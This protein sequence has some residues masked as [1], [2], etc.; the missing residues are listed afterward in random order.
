[1]TLPFWGFSLAV[2]G[3]TIPLAVVSSSSIA[4]T[5]RRS[6]RGLRFMNHDLRLKCATDARPAWHSTIE[7]ASA[8]HYS[9]FRRQFG[10]LLRRVPRTVRAVPRAGRRVASGRA[11]ADRDRLREALGPRRAPRPT[12]RRAADAA[13]RQGGVSRRSDRARAA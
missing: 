5:I 9:A 8:R 7:S 11:L 13:R 1:M 2:S 10:T 6:P 4:R 3:R 12:G